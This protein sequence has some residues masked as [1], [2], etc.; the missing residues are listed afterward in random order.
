VFQWRTQFGNK[1]TGQRNMFFPYY[2][3][4]IISGPA[5]FDPQKLQKELGAQTNPGFWFQLSTPKAP[6]LWCNID[7]KLTR[8]GFFQLWC[9]IYP[10][11]HRLRSESFSFLSDYLSNA[12]FP[13]PVRASVCSL[14]LRIAST[15]ARTLVADSVGR[16][17]G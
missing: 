11:C 8:S 2:L 16:V 12:S 1:C 10:F 15:P 4:S 13:S 9:N 7:L 17:P 14:A 5:A 6:K 3:D